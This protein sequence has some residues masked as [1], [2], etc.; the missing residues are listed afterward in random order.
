MTKYKVSLFQTGAE[1][2]SLL[3]MIGNHNGG[4]VPVGLLDLVSYATT[5]KAQLP[6]TRAGFQI[7]ISPED[8]STILVSEDGGK[9]FTLSI[10]EI[11]V[12]ELEG[13]G[14]LAD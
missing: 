7:T 4:I 14:A 10:T 12:F 2:N 11:E 9:S 5:Q 8:S 13:Q 6:L 1:N 3:T